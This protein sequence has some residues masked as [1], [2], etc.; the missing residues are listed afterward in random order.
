MGEPFLCRLGFH[1]WRDIGARV[2]VFWQ[3]PTVLKA[4]IKNTAGT[5]AGSQNCN[6]TTH[7]KTVYEGRMCKRCGMK[8]KRIFI[9]NPDGT[10]AAVGWEDAAEE[11]DNE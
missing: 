11:T 10:L 3:E 7:K 4:G 6:I 8:L 2:E 9:T 5:L 1:E